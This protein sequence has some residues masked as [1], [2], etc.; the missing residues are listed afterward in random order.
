MRQFPGSYTVDSLL[1]A[2]AYELLELR[3]LLDPELGKVRD[4]G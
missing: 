1:R 4:G 3:A 2:D